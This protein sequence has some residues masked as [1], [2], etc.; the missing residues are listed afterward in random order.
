MTR[1]TILQYLYC[2]VLALPLR[3]LAQTNTTWLAGSTVDNTVI[4]RNNFFV[5]GTS[6]MGGL[7]DTTGSVAGLPVGAVRVRPQDSLVYMFTGR[8]TGRKWNAISTAATAGVTAITVNGG[9]NQVGIVNLTIPTNNNQLTN[10]LNFIT[11]AGAPV[12]SVNGQTNN[13]T[14]DATIVH[15][16]GDMTNI[17]VLGNGTISTPFQVVWIG[18]KTD[19][20]WRTQG[21]DSIQFLI[22]GRY[23]SILD[24]LGG[25]SG[26]GVTTASGD[27]N[28]TASGTNL[29]LTVTAVQGKTITLAPGLLRYSGTAFSFDNSTFLTTIAGITAGGDLTGTYANPTI[30][31]NAVTNAKAAQ[32]GPNTVKSNITGSLANAS[33]NSI[34]SF[35]AVLSLATL[36]AQG[37][38]PPAPH[39]GMKLGMVGGTITWQDTTAGGG[40][41]VASVS[42]SDATLAI[43]PTTGVVVASL[44]LTHANT[45]PVLQTFGTLTVTS[46]LKLTGL[47]SAGANDS[48]LTINPSTFVVG[49]ASRFIPIGA[50]NGLQ[51]LGS[52]NDSVGLGGPLTQNTTIAMTGFT[53]STTGLGN[54]ATALG[55]D[56]VLLIDAAGRWWK[57]PVPSGGGGIVSSVANSDGTL[58]ITPT[59]GAVVGSINLAH[60]NTWSAAQTFTSP[61]LTT[62]STVGFAWTANNTSGAGAWASLS[63]KKIFTLTAHGFILNE[64]L[65]INGSGVP[66]AADTT[67]FASMV[68]SRVIDANNFEVNFSGTY[69]NTAHGLTVGAYYYV[70]MPAGSLTST[71][72]TK[73]QPV[74]YIIDA[75][76]ILVTIQ[77]PVDFSG[78]NSSL[79]NVGSGQ[80][81]GVLGTLNMKTLLGINGVV[82]DSTTNANSLTF[83]V[84]SS[85]YATLNYVLTHGGSGGSLQQAIDFAK[86]GHAYLTHADT[87]FGQN[88][89]IFM[90]S[91]SK[92]EI[93]NTFTGSRR[94]L[95]M[96]VTNGIFG[97]AGLNYASG[98]LAISGFSSYSIGS[99]FSVTDV[100]AVTGAGNISMGT[101]LNIGASVS[102]NADQHWESLLSD[103]THFGVHATGST[104]TDFS[105]I[106]GNLNGMF[107]HLT[108][109]GTLGAGIIVDVRGTNIPF[110]WAVCGSGSSS[111]VVANGISSTGTFMCGPA[112]FAN[113]ADSGKSY[114]QF[115]AQTTTKAPMKFALNGAVAV[116]TT[117]AGLLQA[118]TTHL[119]Y[120]DA[121]LV[122]HDLL[123]GAT[124]IYTADGT[125]SGNRTVTVGGSSL[126]FSASSGSLTL[127]STGANIFLNTGSTAGTGLILS[128]SLYYGFTGIADANLTIADGFTF[129]NLPGSITA[130]RTITLPSAT[131]DGGRTLVIYSPTPSGGFNWSFSSTVNYPDG[132]GTLGVLKG[133]TFYV[134]QAFNGVWFVAAEY[135]SGVAL[136][137]KHTIFAPTTGN[138]IT[139]INNQNNIVN[140]S[141]TIAALTIALPSSPNPNDVVKLT[142]TQAVTVI[143]Y[144]GGTVV[145]LP[146]TAA[147]G[148]Q[149][150]LNWDAGT[151]TWY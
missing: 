137:E 133:G 22:N 6:S 82:I 19:S 144:S 35:E 98:N 96:S 121:N 56:S 38:A 48:V 101:A 116:T 71:S 8:T 25:G 74:L 12:Q 100:G 65:Y 9:G 102:G 26:G 104:H 73:S 16:A 120:T 2:L 141:G 83:Q 15:M 76:T 81:L 87:L 105:Y 20:V 92:L 29:P 1:K 3:G 103:A 70:T 90:D 109:G 30:A 134:L 79:V 24:S 53:F 52:T 50:I 149:W 124:N 95:S 78:V 80:T 131:T 118:Y 111:D 151:S 91:T 42:N 114:M 117:T 123:A 106:G 62:S 32:M 39:N 11:A 142:F 23:H 77:R 128:A 59:T 122:D 86:T 112:V 33:D 41:A 67:N 89:G 110:Y 45:W 21:K 150:T 28:G 54:K 119:V 27:A 94:A 84:D 47:A 37:L 14:I 17:N 18:P 66:T 130:S 146:T 145:G 99:L 143:T 31:A 132:T 88:T 4:A 61:I 51:V 49:W 60:A 44:N 113:A 148:S 34:A 136:K 46:T 107:G 10:G 13:V 135:G 125:L 139:T 108:T 68:V 72:P 43:S 127:T 55:T 126:T 115:L 147:I 58:T 40:G 85:K 129:Y 5:N 75:N 138:T 69:T 64:P 140:P 93:A 7:H 97:M 63:T 36:S 57:L